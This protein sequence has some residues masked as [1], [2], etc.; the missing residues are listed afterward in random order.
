MQAAATG[1][2]KADVVTNHI[3]KVQPIIVPTDFTSQVLRYLRR[4]RSITLIIFVLPF[5]NL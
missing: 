1:E 2:Q 5:N 4:F 3:L